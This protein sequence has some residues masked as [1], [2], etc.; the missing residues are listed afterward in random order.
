M[1]TSIANNG[2]QGKVIIIGG[3]IG[4]SALGLFLHKVGI[5]CVIYEAYAYKEG[6]GGGLA[7]APNG[8]NVLAALGLA[9]KVKARGSLGLENVFYNQKGQILAR[10]PN[11]TVTQYGQNAVSLMRPAL[12]DVLCEEIN[13]LGIPV[14]YCKRLTAITQ[15]DQKVIAHF[16]DGTQDEGDLLIGAD[17][18]RSQTRR[19]ILPTA[20]QPEFINII[21]VGGVVPAADLPMMTTRDRQNFHFTFG[22]KGFFGYCGAENGDVM[23]WANLASEKEFTREEITRVR[24]DALQRELMAIF[25]GYHQPIET[26]IHKM[27]APLKMNIYDIQSLPKW[28]QG[29]V[30]L[31]GD[32]AHAVSPNSG[33]GASMAM[34]DAMYLAKLLR[35]MSDYRQVFEQ[36]EA[37]RKPRVEKIVAEGR[38]RGSD[39]KVTSAFQQTVREFMMR[40]FV[41]LFAQKGQDWMYA[42][43]IDWN[44]G[45]RVPR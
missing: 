33:Q 9:E 11:G 3:G 26:I 27:Q 41:N 42:Y 18:V 36:F 21:G 1:T 4:G 32:S 14:H 38:R 13:R 15:T 23:W 7:I 31:I 8:M 34:E 30:V 28:N 39:K 16:E 44:E 19:L 29:R 43:K 2:F 25:R 37:H 24:I 20:P 22:A 6:V 45:E 10:Y 35:D 40:I 17:G 12:Y 5:P